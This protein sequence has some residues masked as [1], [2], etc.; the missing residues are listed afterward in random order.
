MNILH[1]DT[2]DIDGRAFGQMLLGLP[3]DE[4]GAE[5]I[6]AYLAA[7]GVQFSQI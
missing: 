7:N 2:Q 6:K 5:K 1:A 3:D 4:R